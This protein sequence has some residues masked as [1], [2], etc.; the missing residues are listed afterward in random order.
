MRVGADDAFLSKRLRGLTIEEAE[1]LLHFLHGVLVGDLN[2]ELGEKEPTIREFIFWAGLLL[3]A[4]ANQ[5]VLGC[6]KADSHLEDR[7]KKVQREVR[8]VVSIMD[9]VEAVKARLTSLLVP[10]G[11]ASGRSML[12]FAKISSRSSDYSVATT[13]FFD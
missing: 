7:L 5:F 11:G 4:K 3:D 6:S 13:D 10:K 8:D 9:D 1:L 2:R 12:S